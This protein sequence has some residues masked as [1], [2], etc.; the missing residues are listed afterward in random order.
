MLLIFLLIL[1]SRRVSLKHQLLLQLPK[2]FLIILLLK[3][4]TIYANKFNTQKKRLFINVGF[5]LKSATFVENNFKVTFAPFLSLSHSL[6]G[7]SFDF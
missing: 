2:S 3:F 5:D 4:S 1:S 7:S 6:F